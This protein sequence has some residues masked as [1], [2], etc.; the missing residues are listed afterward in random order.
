[1]TAEHVPAEEVEP[2]RMVAFDGARYFIPDSS[3]ELP[4]ITKWDW[5]PGPYMTRND[6]QI[7]AEQRIAVAHHRPEGFVHISDC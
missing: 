4:P 3:L 2:G 1:M 6:I 7:L 5:T